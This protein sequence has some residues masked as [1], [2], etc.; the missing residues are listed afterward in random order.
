MAIKRFLNELIDKIKDAPDADGDPGF[1]YEV[2]SV[3]A[4]AD[5]RNAQF[6]VHDVETGQCFQ[7]TLTEITR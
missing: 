7:I 6:V 1:A 5:D 4:S 3:T 2:K